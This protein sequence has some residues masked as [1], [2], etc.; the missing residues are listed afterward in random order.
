MIPPV[1]SGRDILCFYISPNRGLILSSKFRIVHIVLE[2]APDRAEAIVIAVEQTVSAR[3]QFTAKGMPPHNQQDILRACGF[4]L[5]RHIPRDGRVS[6]GCAIVAVPVIRRALIQFPGRRWQSTGAAI[7][8]SQNIIGNLGFLF[9][10][11]I[12]IKLAFAV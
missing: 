9:F 10:R 7:V 6:Q 2:Q 5:V 12:I 3:I 11:S 4:H 1:L 8:G